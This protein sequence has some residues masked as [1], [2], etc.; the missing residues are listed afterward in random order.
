MLQ[1]DMLQKVKTAKFYDL[2][3]YESTN[4]GNWQNLVL[5]I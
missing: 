1:D 4:I 5:C 3:I 2:E